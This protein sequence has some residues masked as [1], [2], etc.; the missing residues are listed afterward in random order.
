MN[1]LFIFYFNHL[2]STFYL[3][4]RGE[5]ITVY[6]IRT[7]AP[8]KIAARSGLVFGFGIGSFLGLGA[9]FLEGNWPKTT[10]YM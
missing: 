2:F 4:L 7:I 9:T 10:V 5:A 8:R 6:G 1:E 3:I